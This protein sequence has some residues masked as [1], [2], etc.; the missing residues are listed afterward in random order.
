MVRIAHLSD[1][2]LGLRS[3]YF[4]DRTKQDERRNDINSSFEEAVSFC[5]APDNAINVVLITGDLFDSHNPDD[6]ILQFARTQLRRLTRANKNVL[7]VPGSNDGFHYADSVY[8]HENF[9]GIEIVTNPDMDLIRSIEIENH[10]LNFYGMTYSY[11]SI[12]PFDMFERQKLPGFHIALMHGALE[13]EPGWDD[14]VADVPLRLENLYATGFDYIALGQY[15]QF[16]H[17][18]NGNVHV[19][20][21]GSLEAIKPGETGS[22]GIVVVEFGEDGVQVRQELKGMGR[23]HFEDIQINLESMQIESQSQLLEFIRKRYA[24]PLG[25]VR[26]QLE[27]SI[28]FI[29]NQLQLKIALDELFYYSEIDDRTV[30]YSAAYLDGVM[31]EN[32]VRGMFLSELNERFRRAESGQDKKVL[33]QAL[34]IG[35]RKLISMDY[36]N[37]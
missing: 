28:P 33:E 27:G 7:L 26:I 13:G 22:R 9:T 34:K 19:V 8:R 2:H 32:T 35:M 29:I 3:F 15:H 31:R 1:I 23:K 30:L 21:P 18:T 14:Q 11:N 5:L 24:D 10:Q 37:E 25:I 20:Y 17:H 6:N 36:F 4:N 12:P 16:Q